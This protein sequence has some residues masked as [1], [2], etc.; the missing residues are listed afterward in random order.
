MKKNLYG[1]KGRRQRL[2]YYTVNEAA[3]LAQTSPDKLRRDIAGG[4]IAR[5]AH[6]LDGYKR[7]FYST[8]NVREITR[9]YLQLQIAGKRPDY[10][11][12]EH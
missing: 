6:E 3:K 10:F 2:G 4:L 8:R 1:N 11:P 5:P 9:F 12:Q 7:K